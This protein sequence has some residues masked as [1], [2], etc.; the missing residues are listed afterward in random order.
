VDNQFVYGISSDET[1]IP[2]TIHPI[3][4]EVI[5]PENILYGI[6]SLD[7]VTTSPLKVNPI[8]GVF[9]LTSNDIVYGV[10][11]LDGKTIT[12]LTINPFVT[13]SN[14]AFSLKGVPFR[15]VGGNYYPLMQSSQAQVQQIFD[16]AVG[17]G[18]TVM[19]TWCFDPMGS[20][21][22]LIYP[23][24]TNILSNNL[25]T[26][27]LTGL[28]NGANGI[29][30]EGAVNGSVFTLV[31]SPTP[32]F[33]SYCLKQNSGVNTYDAIAEPITVIEN[34][35]Y[36]FSFYM[37]GTHT[38]G[39]G[40]QLPPR[41]IVTDVN[42]YILANGGT[43]GNENEWTLVQ[44]PFN[45]GSNTIVYP[46][47]QNYGGQ[48]LFYYNNW[49]V[50][51]ARTPILNYSLSALEQLDMILNEASL[52]GIKLILSLADGNENGYN[53]K[54][55]YVQNCNLIN[56]T[57]YSDTYPYLDFFTSAYIFTMYQNFFYTLAT[58]VNSINGLI[59]MND[60]TIFSWEL[61]NELRTNNYEGGTVN[62]LASTN[63]AIL[64]NPGGWIDIMSTYIKSI[65]KN[66]MVNFGDCAHGWAYE[67]NDIIW[68]GTY[69]GVDYNIIT[70]LPNI[71]FGDF[72]VYPN[73]GD[74]VHL[75]AYG[76][77]LGYPGTSGISQAGFNA[78]LADFVNKSHANGKPAI[79][80]ET[81]F[82][83]GTTGDNTY[84]PL[85][86][87]F[88]AFQ[89]MFQQF[90]DDANGD[91][92]LIWSLQSGGPVGLSYNIALDATGGLLVTDNSNDETIDNLILEY[93]TKFNLVL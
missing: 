87:R 39:D 34:T 80:G 82:V 86:N 9:A 11:S 63:L 77:Y 35:N 40:S 81:G 75:Q 79:I 16:S 6:S 61:G 83:Q 93:N 15:F 68:N 74:G 53:T 30:D 92:L 38:G 20:F 65:D 28:N 50:C 24:G 76:A 8:T 21:R 33:G 23:I 72:H 47:I 62:T 49:N 2:L 3:T 19:R 10:S 12:P 46:T 57:S 84:I 54:G 26:N 59:Y 91:G 4:G 85:Y 88:A 14:S 29:G 42:G 60:P 71:D 64:S 7:G 13:H 44:V 51:L 89:Y 67:A 41:V 48:N 69:D 18:I 90:L 27:S 45:S 17:R 5:T 66:H 58:R 22:Y 70:K 1:I 31:T 43:L 32:E 52:R 56:N 25:T 78:Q 37:Q 55:W 36:V 73:Q